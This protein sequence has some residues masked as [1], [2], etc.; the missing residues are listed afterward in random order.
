MQQLIDGIV[1]LYKHWKKEEPLEIEVLPQSGSDRRYFRLH[2][3]ETNTL[4]AT[5]GLNVKENETFLYFA[6]HFH[7]KDLPVPEIF[8]VNEDKTIYIQEDFGNVSL[9]NILEAKG[10]VPQVYQL[11]KESLN[12][13]ARLQV[14]G[15]KD[16]D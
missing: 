13:L 4:I 3:D 15:D 12:Q 1:Q 16:I 7:R 9:L 11:F 14:L 6:D 8:T 10:Y 5:F 2:T